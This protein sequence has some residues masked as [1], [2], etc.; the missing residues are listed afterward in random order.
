MALYRLY[1][2]RAWPWSREKA[3]GQEV[4]ETVFQMGRHHAAAPSSHDRAYDAAH[5]G[6]SEKLMQFLDGLSRPMDEHLGL[7]ASHTIQIA[8]ACIVVIF[9]LSLLYRTFNPGKPVNQKIASNVGLSK[10]D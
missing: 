3:R 1:S 6:V 4:A 7:N 5:S 10:A 9:L 8:G 2:G